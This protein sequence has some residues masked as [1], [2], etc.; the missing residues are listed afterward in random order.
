MQPWQMMVLAV[1]QGVTELFP[2]SSLGHSV[3]I[4]TL[5]GWHIP[6]TSPD[7]LPFLVVLHIGT[8]SALLLY[9][10]RDW[11]R[12]LGGVWSARG[13]RSNAEA[14]LFWLLV[15][16][17]IPA[18]LIGLFFAKRIK[19]LFA[20]LL[21]AAVFL[22]VN[23]LVLIVGDFLKKRKPSH[24]LTAMTWP[25]ALFIGVAQAFA[26]IPGM[27]RS[28]VTIVAGLG[29]GFDYAAAAR[30]SFLMA[31]PI[32]AAAGLLEVPKLFHIQGPIHL[33]AIVASGLIAG[34]FAYA[35][36][37]IL[38]RYFNKQE[39]EALRPFGLYCLALGAA[40]LVWHFA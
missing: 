6:P 12:L 29:K 27:S 25:K 11:A 33:E 14:R 16:A 36:T 32:I 34:V 37:W 40:A 26:L 24:Q 4:R 2:I 39:V 15:V 3:L 23:G 35:S 13:G 20:N 38:M 30:F 28:G 7:F 17:S 9:F 18:G 21:V 10:W 8:A 22:M 5:S 1:V 19:I 31:T